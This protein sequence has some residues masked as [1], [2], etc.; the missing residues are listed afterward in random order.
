MQISSTL[1]VGLVAAVI[2]VILLIAAAL[3]YAFRQIGRPPEN[4]PDRF[5]KRG[6]SSP[7]QR[8]VVC[9]GASMVHG[10]VGVNFVDLVAQR[11]SSG[12]SFVNA[13]VNGDT[14]Y[15]A[16]QRLESV[17][18]CQPDFVVVLV[19]TNDVI[20]T[21]DPGVWRRYRGAKRLSQPPSIDGYREDLRDIVRQLKQRTTAHIALCSLPVL[22]EALPSLANER[23]SDFNAVIREIAEQGAVS[24]LP[25]FERESV[26]LAEQQQRSQTQGRPFPGDGKG[27]LPGMVWASLQHYLFGSSFDAISRRNGLLLK[28]DLIHGNSQEAAII[29]DLIGDFL[30]GDSAH[31]DLGQGNGVHDGSS[32]SREEPS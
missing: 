31:A 13:G 20:S 27:Y 2:L 30:Q 12:Y 14:A 4:A 10:R 5:L 6:R 23:V 1:A 16:R 8:V 28:T 25:V 9:L 32:S 19:G 29:A 24:Y 26:W 22:G 15:H 18:A 21:L 3:A 7:D 17:I 11:F